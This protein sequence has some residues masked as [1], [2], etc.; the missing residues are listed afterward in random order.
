MNVSDRDRAN[1]PK[2]MSGSLPRKSVQ[3]RPIILPAANNQD[4]T[5]VEVLTA[6]K[7]T[8]APRK[9]GSQ[10]Y[11]KPNVIILIRIILS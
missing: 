4:C 1:H 3:S 9:T 2:F 10:E 7:D 11:G 8:S 6:Q 5:E